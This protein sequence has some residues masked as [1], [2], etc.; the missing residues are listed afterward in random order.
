MCVCVSMGQH[1]CI[2]DKT[3]STA[4]RKEKANNTETMPNQ[5]LFFH[6]D[7]YNP[8]HWG[9]CGQCLLWFSNDRFDTTLLP[10]SDGRNLG[11]QVYLY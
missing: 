9:G 11:M 6:R 2:K 10:M 1:C 8:S 7:R 3:R 5:V 4:Y